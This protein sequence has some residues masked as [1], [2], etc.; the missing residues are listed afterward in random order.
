MTAM[1]GLKGQRVDVLSGNQTLWLTPL[2][3][4]YGLPNKWSFLPRPEAVNNP[5]T[6]QLVEL[7]SPF[8][9]SSQLF[10]L[11]PPIFSNTEALANQA[12]TVLMHRFYISHFTKD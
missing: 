11:H 8:L 3:L 4:L 9:A 10:L 2:N 6:Q 5:E 7:L 12:K 1:R